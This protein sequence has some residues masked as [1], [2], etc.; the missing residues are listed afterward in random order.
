MQEA[1]YVV[2]G[3]IVEKIKEDVKFIDAVLHLEVQF[4]ATQEMTDLLKAYGRLL[5]H[6]HNAIDQ[7]NSVSIPSY[8]SP[9]DPIGELLAL[10]TQEINALHAKHELVAS[11]AWLQTNKPKRSLIDAGGMLLKSLFG[12]ATNGDLKTINEQVNLVEKA[13]HNSNVALVQMQHDQSALMRHLAGLDEV[14]QRVDGQKEL[15]PF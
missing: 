10:F 5:N 7:L 14:L 2:P 8:T 15:K 13:L 9:G 12:V 4:F 11:F 1:T 3:T 6:M